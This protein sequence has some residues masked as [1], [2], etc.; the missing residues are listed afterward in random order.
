MGGVCLDDAVLSEAATSNKLVIFL[1]SGAFQNGIAM[2]HS[3][4]TYIGAVFVTFGTRHVRI[5]HVTM[6]LFPPL[7]ILYT[8]SN[9]A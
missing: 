2:T 5:C 8:G 9:N 4:L 7:L 1:A 6:L 3:T